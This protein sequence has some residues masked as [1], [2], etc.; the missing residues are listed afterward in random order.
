MKTEKKPTKHTPE[1][2]HKKQRLKEASDLALVQ[3]HDELETSKH[4]TETLIRNTL[5]I[6]GG[7]TLAY[8]AVRIITAK[9]PS[10]KKEKKNKRLSAEFPAREQVHLSPPAQAAVAVSAKAMPAP[11]RTRHLSASW[12]RSAHDCPGGA[13]RPADRIPQKATE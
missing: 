7:L 10:E 6:A 5:L 1:L 3:L 9:G 2:E 4:N 13:E 12:Q 11:S 8:M